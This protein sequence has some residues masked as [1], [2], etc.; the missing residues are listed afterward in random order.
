MNPQDQAGWIVAIVAGFLSFV[1]PCVLP[2]IPGY[3]SMISG[4]S[5]E[6]LEEKSGRT[7]GRIFVSCILFSVGLCAVFI[8][9]GLGVGA[10]GSQLSR[11]MT[12]INV[13]FGL[14]VIFFGLFVLNVVQ[15][16]TLYRDRHFRLS[17]G[18]IG[19]W[20]APLL[21]IAFGFGWTPCIGPWLAGLMGIALNQGPVQSAVLFGVFGVTFGLCF[22][23]AGMLF[24]YALR[25]FAFLQRNYRAI[26]VVSGV[27][28]VVIGILLVTQQWDRVTGYLMRAVG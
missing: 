5:S 28:L 18:S 26:E 11:Y 1:S 13:I 6:E 17:R 16:P 9:V 8:V 20:G 19:L 12:I 7:L 27:L 3:L 23:I 10:V 15:L 21:G 4:L 14:V 24:A 22:V 25:A 2:L